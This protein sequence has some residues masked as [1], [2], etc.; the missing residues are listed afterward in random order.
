MDFLINF[1]DLLVKSFKV[2]I[3]ML[4]DI[5]FDVYI[6]VFG[7]FFVEDI[8]VVKENCKFLFIGEFFMKRIFVEFVGDIF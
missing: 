8:L 2:G 3:E 6:E 5:G 1:V 7:K 4:L